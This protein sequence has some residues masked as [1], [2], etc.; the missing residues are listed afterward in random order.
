MSSSNIKVYSFLNQSSPNFQ[1]SVSVFLH[2]CLFSSFSILVKWIFCPC[3]SVKPSSSYYA[4]Y[5]VCVGGGG[6][7]G[8]GPEGKSVG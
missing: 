6:G 2:V 8:G 3:L 4:K 5:Y 7:G 1:L